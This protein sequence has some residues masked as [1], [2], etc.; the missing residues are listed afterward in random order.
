MY[1]QIPVQNN[2]IYGQNYVL[3][4]GYN[5]KAVIFPNN[6][7][8]QVQQNNPLGNPVQMKVGGDMR[9]TYTPGQYKKGQMIY[10]VPQQPLPGLQQTVI[11]NLPKEHNHGHYIQN[12]ISPAQ[13]QGFQPIYPNQPNKLITQPQLQNNQAQ[14]KPTESNNYDYKKSASLMTVKSLANIPYSEYPQAEYSDKPFCNIAG[15][16]SNSYNGK[17]RNYNEDRTKIIVDFKK[18][19]VVN[20]QKITPNISYFSVFDGHG[21]KA[22]SDFLRDNL[23]N[24]LFN[25]RY[26]PANPIQAIK[27]AFIIAENEFYKKAYDPQRNALLDRSGSCALIILIINDLLYAINLGDC[28]ALLS[29]DSGT[30]LFQI[31]RDHKPNDQIEKRRIEKYGAKVYYANK[32]NI[33]GKEVEL[34]EKDY[35]EGFTFPYRIAPGGISV[36][37]LFLNLFFFY[38]LGLKNYR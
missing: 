38:Y 11:Q 34:K 33:N 24:Y 7:Q 14:N 35:G 23:H 32:V 19:L 4:V 26:F 36:S 37:S 2:Q 29:S 27:E 3:P 18:T 21:G 10:Q 25:S 13:P 9:K 1:G 15:Y 22:C 6:I 16:A 8:Y 28:R 12:Q 17:V 20:G 5:P 30:N 31:T